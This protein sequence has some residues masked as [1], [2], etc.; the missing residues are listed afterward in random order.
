MKLRNEEPLVSN[1]SYSLPRLQVCSDMAGRERFKD[2]LTN[3]FK[4]FRRSLVPSR[5]RSP[6]PDRSID[7]ALDSLTSFTPIRSVFS[8]NYGI[9][10]IQFTNSNLSSLSIPDIQPPHYNFN[11]PLSIPVQHNYNLNSPS[12]S[13]PDIQLPESSPPKKSPKVA[14]KPQI[15]PDSPPREV[16]DLMTRFQGSDMPLGS[17]PHGSRSSSPLY[18]SPYGSPLPP[19]MA[20]DGYGY[21][22]GYGG[23]S[24]GMFF[25]NNTGSVNNTIIGNVSIGNVNSPSFS[26][27]DIPHNYSYNPPSMSLPDIQPLNFNSSNFDASI[28]IDPAG[29]EAPGR[30]ANLAIARF[31]GVKMTLRLVERATDVFPTLKST[32]ASLLSVIDIMEVR[33]FQLNV[34]IVMVL[35]VSR[36][37]LR[38]N[39]IAEIWSRS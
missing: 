32:V 12:F 23:G 31:Q 26:I 15:P 22:Y 27:P 2:R 38:T 4:Q 39:R 7:P 8:S 20:R 1:L 35:T 18:Y 11:P 28:V 36:Q 16:D 33:D 17:S 37:P 29:D 6:P 30:M 19:S 3:K 10:D 34:V 25:N 21:G 13:N 14:H 5:N 24:A 9:P